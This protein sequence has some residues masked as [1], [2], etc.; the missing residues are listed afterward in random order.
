MPKPNGN[1]ILKIETGIEVHA[2][3]IYGVRHEKQR[4]LKAILENQT[5]FLRR[6]GAVEYAVGVL[7]G[8]GISI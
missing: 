3:R 4:Q 5:H 8:R 7:V 6:E 2:D 1:T